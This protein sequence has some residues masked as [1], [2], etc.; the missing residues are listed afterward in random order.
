MGQK[1]NIALPRSLEGDAKAL[2]YKHSAALRLIPLWKSLATDGALLTR[3]RLL[4]FPKIAARY[5][6]SDLRIDYE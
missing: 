1:S 3:A 2:S 4:A 5:F 6:L